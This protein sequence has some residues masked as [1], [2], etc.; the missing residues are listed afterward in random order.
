M[1]KQLMPPARLRS[2]PTD[3]P[4]TDEFFPKISLFAQLKQKPSLDKFPG[5][6]VLRRYRQGDVICQ[7]GDAAWTAFY[8]LT[9]EDVLMLRARQAQPG[10]EGTVTLYAL[11]IVGLQAAAEDEM[12]R[13]ATAYLT[14]AGRTAHTPGLLERLARRWRGEPRGDDMPPESIPIDGPT[15]IDYGSMQA[16]VHE[17]ELFGEMSCMY[18]TPRS[19]TI[20]ADRDCYMLEMLR[21]VLTQVQKDPAYR[22]KIDETYK[23][24]VFQLHLRRLSLFADLTDDQFAWARD[25]VDLVTR[26]PGQVVYDEYD[27]ADNV[28]IIRSGLVRVVKKASALYQAE[29]V[30]SW[31]NLAAVLCQ[32]EAEPATKPGGHLW[33]LLPEKV[34]AACRAAAQPGRPADDVRRDLLA[35]LNDLVKTMHESELKTKAPLPTAEPFRPFTVNPDFEA[36]LED[37]PPNWRQQ[38]ADQEFR[39]FNRLVLD[40]VLNCDR[41]DKDRVVRAYQRR[42]GPDCV[43]YYCSRGEFVGE[44]VWQGQ[45]LRQES[46]LAYGHPMDAASGKVAGPV[47]LVSIPKAVFDEL[48]RLP[49]IRRRVER[50]IVERTRQTQERVRLPV[51]DDSRQVQ[52]SEQFERLGLIQGQRLMLI[53]LDRCTRCDEC[54]RACVDSHDDGRSRLFLDGPRFG[55]YLVPTS[56]RSCLDPVCMIGCPVGSIHRGDNGQIVIE[57]WCI[58]CSLCAEQCPYG[59]I[60]MHDIGYIAEKARGWRYLT[61][62]AVG[63]AAWTEP[64]YNDAR[65]PQGAGPFVNTRQFRDTLYPDR[66]A[67]GRAMTDSSHYPRASMADSLLTQYRS[68]GITR[69]T[70][71]VCFRYAFSL[72]RD[73]ARGGRRFKLE[74]TSM[75]PAVAVW[76]NGVPLETTDRP[77]R[78]GKREYWI[79]PKSPTEE[80]PKVLRSG[81][82]VLAV[83]VTPDTTS[84]GEVILKVR[85]DEVLKPSA[86]GEAAEEVTQKL[87]TERAVVCDLCSGQ[88]GQVPACVNA[89]PHDAA[90]RV[91]ARTDFPVR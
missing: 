37:L 89:C 12:R 59:S 49:A 19:V 72:S 47:E 90:V 73:A 45:Q 58:G 24:R 39:R 51:Y 78:D 16:P 63:N 11:D 54:V 22:A 91:D 61:S 86:G 84:Q 56:C 60:Q 48:C 25:Q 83:Q 79:G 23:K 34:R 64:G 77:R 20:V 13:V 1:A 21:N 2:R 57:D 36:C 85:L 67:D 28:Y 40:A 6:L 29:Q 75:Y 81:R 74:L 27:Q 46:C 44:L 76:M 66:Q 71:P 43:L 15:D 80:G 55:K 70:E 42:I 14:T 50:K 4:L 33:N 30:R 38:W 10:P 65:W 8:V 26:D 69:P 52:F 7:Q 5:T 18:G 68:L 41:P 17:G 82:N 87:V 35:G 62:S 88:L 32:G 3:V 31:Q 9:S 53:D